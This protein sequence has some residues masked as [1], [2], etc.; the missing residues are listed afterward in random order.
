MEFSTNESENERSRNEIR[1]HN[2]ANAFE[3][4]CIEYNQLRVRMM[5][6]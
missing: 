1:M 2:K 4:K 3:N 6:M 5:C